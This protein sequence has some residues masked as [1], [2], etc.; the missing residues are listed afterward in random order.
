MR[1]VEQALINW[2]A[3]KVRENELLGSKD[4]SKFPEGEFRKRHVEV[5]TAEQPLFALGTKL[6]AEQK[7]RGKQKRQASGKA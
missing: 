1:E 6:L 2:T 7:P 4:W 5:L 3:A